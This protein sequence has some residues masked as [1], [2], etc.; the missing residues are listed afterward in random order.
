MIKGMQF[1]FLLKTKYPSK[2]PKEMCQSI[3]NIYL[4]SLYESNQDKKSKNLDDFFLPQNRLESLIWVIER[5]P[6]NILFFFLV[7]NF[8]FSVKFLFQS[9]LKSPGVKKRKLKFLYKMTFSEHI[10]LKQSTCMA[11]GAK[12]LLKDPSLF[13]K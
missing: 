6:K 2:K 12:F 5:F 9:L 3:Y 10:Q 8:F 13:L 7:S 4:S 11:F 1:F